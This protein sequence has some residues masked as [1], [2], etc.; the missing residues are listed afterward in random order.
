MSMLTCSRGDCTNIMCDRFN[1]EL[2]YICDE[3]FAELV[4][5]NTTDVAAFME[6][7]PATGRAHSVS[8]REH[9]EEIFPPC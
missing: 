8:L 1:P 6:T 5:S 2:G 9:Y 7:N 3:C 4:A